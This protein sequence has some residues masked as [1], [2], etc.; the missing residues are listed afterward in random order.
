VHR[1]IFTFYCVLKV[2]FIKLKRPL[3]NVIGVTSLITFEGRSGEAKSTMGIRNQV[4]GLER[5][6]D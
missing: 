3:V 4:K 5:R 1:G 2:E 6:E